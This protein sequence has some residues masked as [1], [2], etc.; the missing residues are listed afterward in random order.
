MTIVNMVGGGGATSDI[1]ITQI[2]R[3]DL[4]KYPYPTYTSVT[5]AGYDQKPWFRFNSTAGAVLMKIDDNHYVSTNFYVSTGG[6]TG[7]SKRV[8]KQRITSDTNLRF[9]IPFEPK[10]GDKVNVFWSLDDVTYVEQ[11]PEK[12][13]DYVIEY[14]VSSYVTY[15]EGVTYTI[16]LTTEQ[17][18][19]I[20]TELSPASG[21]RATPKILSYTKT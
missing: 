3:C 8:S 19:Y 18:V 10:V 12:F 17:T 21:K 15:N 7:G 5:G 16:T 4:D 13:S 2:L 20:L 1:N 9:D 14:T 11:D 6:S